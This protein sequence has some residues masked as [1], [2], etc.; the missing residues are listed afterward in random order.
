MQL[1]P[2]EFIK[3]DFHFETMKLKPE[4]GYVNLCHFRWHKMTICRLFL[5]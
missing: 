4:T 2:Q 5:A 3:I 1:H